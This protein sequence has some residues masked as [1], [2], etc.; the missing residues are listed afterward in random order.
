M[1]YNVFGGM[2]NFTQSIYKWGR[3]VVFKAPWKG[4]LVIYQIAIADSVTI[5]V[6]LFTN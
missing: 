3:T 2:L 1:T 4:D 6:L 5:T